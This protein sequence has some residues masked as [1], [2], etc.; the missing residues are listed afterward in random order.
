MKNLILIAFFLTMGLTVVS[1]QSQGCPYNGQTYPPGTKLGPY[2]C[3]PD[4]TWG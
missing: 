2:T 1:A 3:Q 4:G